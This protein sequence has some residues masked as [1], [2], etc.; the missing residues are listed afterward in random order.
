MAV[1]SGQRA[2]GVAMSAI[3]AQGGHERETMRAFPPLADD[4]PLVAGHE[5]AACG[6]PFKAGERTTVVPL[7]PGADVEAQARAR[8]GRWY[9]CLG[10]I[11]HA[12][13]A[14]VEEDPDA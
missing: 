4:H 9:S 7:G 6:M 2:L 10:V 11:A 13:C 5:C 12:A 14:G 1:V 3:R 8:D